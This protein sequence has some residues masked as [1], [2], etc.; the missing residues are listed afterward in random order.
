M[1]YTEI[2]FEDIKPILDGKS[3]LGDY[4]WGYGSNSA[5]L[6]KK[7][8]AEDGWDVYK[9]IDTNSKKTN[10]YNRDYYF[11]S[12]KH[13]CYVPIAK[14]FWDNDSFQEYLDRAVGKKS[15]YTVKVDL[16]NKK[17]GRRIN[18]GRFVTATD[19]A[20]AKSQA[21]K[22]FNAG[23]RDWAIWPASE[24]DMDLKSMKVKPR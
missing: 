8:T 17:D 11:V 13:K 7:V 12:E 22:D 19:T 24:W 23:K 14:Q 16:I 4:G 6:I 15:V 10:G 21:Q 18:A 5:S 2:K 3:N 20:D 9:V 1:E